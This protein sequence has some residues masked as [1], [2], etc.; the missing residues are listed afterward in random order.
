MTTSTAKIDSLSKHLPG[1]CICI[2]I[3]R[4][5][6]LHRGASLSGHLVSGEESLWQRDNGEREQP[7][8]FLTG[9]DSKET[10]EKHKKRKTSEILSVIYSTKLNNKLNGN[11]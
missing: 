7:A 3:R 10:P 11:V 9:K 4:K 8:T 6:G 5:K 1:N 2:V